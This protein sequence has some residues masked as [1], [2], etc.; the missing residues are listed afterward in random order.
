[1]RIYINQRLFVCSHARAQVSV[2]SDDGW[3]VL[4]F[5]MRGLPAGVERS[6]PGRPGAAHT[7]SASALSWPSH[8]TPSVSVAQ[9]SSSR[10]AECATLKRPS[11]LIAAVTQA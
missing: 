5:E 6:R 3:S 1:M 4:A 9:R 10:A 7:R 11:A 2:T 8:G